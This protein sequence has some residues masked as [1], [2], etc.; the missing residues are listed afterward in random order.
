MLTL[1]SNLSAQVIEEN[2]K[3][4]NLFDDLKKSLQDIK[5]RI[6][7]ENPNAFSTVSETTAAKRKSGVYTK[8]FAEALGVSVDTL[9]SWEIEESEPSPTAKRLMYLISEDP[10]LIEKLKEKFNND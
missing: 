5:N 2:F 7:V 3:D 4:Y 6:I 9:D 10:S 1:K 8:D